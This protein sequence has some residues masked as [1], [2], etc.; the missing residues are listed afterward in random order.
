ML[1]RATDG[2]LFGKR[3]TTTVH[4]PTRTAFNVVPINTQYL[5]PFVMLIRIVPT[6]RFGIAIDTEAAN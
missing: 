2:P 6:D 1:L 4:F 3:I 5:L